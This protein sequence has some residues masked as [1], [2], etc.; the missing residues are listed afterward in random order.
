MTCP[1]EK[2]HPVTC[3]MSCGYFMWF[4]VSPWVCLLGAPLPASCVHSHSHSHSHT[5][6]LSTCSSASLCNDDLICS[7]CVSLAPPLSER[8]YLSSLF[9]SACLVCVLLSVQ[10]E[11][12]W[13][14]LSCQSLQFFFCFWSWFMVHLLFCF[15]LDFGRLGLVSCILLPPVDMFL[16][17]I[18][19]IT[20]I[21][22]YVVCED[23]SK[24]NLFPLINLNVFNSQTDINSFL[25][26]WHGIP[27]KEKNS[28]TEMVNSRLNT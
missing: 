11:Y 28:W 9:L 6:W 14:L 15:W 21:Y 8:L 25:M 4:F 2:L 10:P 5:P 12:S 19:Y 16:N 24:H 20:K 1:F 22:V 17:P 26:K 18:K 3:S 13:L 7:T 27:G 23:S